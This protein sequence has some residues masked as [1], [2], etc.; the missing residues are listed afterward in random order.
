MRR[1]NLHIDTT[2]QFPGEK[3]L[4]EGSFSKDTRYG[5]YG[6][7]TEVHPEDNT[8]HVRM[9][10]GRELSGLRVASMEWVT[11][12]DEKGF[13]SGQRRLPPVNTFVFCI[14]PDGDPS[15]GLVLC[16]V[17]GFQV[18]KHAAFKEKS[19]DAKHT[20][21]RVTNSGWFFTEDNRTGTKIA[22]NREKDETIKFEIDQEEKGNE[23][24]TVTIHGN[25]FT[26]DKDNGI[27][28]ETDKNQVSII[29]K[30]RTVK[31]GGDDNLKVKGK[32][33]KEIAGDADW[34][35]GGNLTENIKG[36]SS[37]TIGGNKTIKAATINLN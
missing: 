29:E 37:E 7:V 30:D 13:L 1:V 27:K 17:F 33:K 5:F 28:I 32:N 16:S 21:K 18:A 4:P 15:R 2:V 23:K 35:I 24:V 9:D 11:I 8:V 34:T 14:T 19:E 20:R 31:I 22:K 25:I 3:K 26:V 36:N 12:D 10:T 6:M